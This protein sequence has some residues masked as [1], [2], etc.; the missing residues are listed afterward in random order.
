[1]EFTYI[2]RGFRIIDARMFPKSHDILISPF[3]YA[4]PRTIGVVATYLLAMQMP[5]VRFS[6]GAFWI[7]RAGAAEIRITSVNHWQ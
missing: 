2:F 4:P 7:F 3:L 5:R 6:D 1:M